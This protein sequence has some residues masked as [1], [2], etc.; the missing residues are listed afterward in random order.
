MNFE[1]KINKYYNMKKDIIIKLT[2]NKI[3]SFD[4]NLEI[5]FDEEYYSKNLAIFE[6]N[7]SSLIFGTSNF[8]LKKDHY[9]KKECDEW[10]GIKDCTGLGT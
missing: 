4:N 2:N 7:K 8:K 5:I 1:E 6:N 3:N 9:F 10:C